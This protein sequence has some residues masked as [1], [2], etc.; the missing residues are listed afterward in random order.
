MTAAAAAPWMRDSRVARLLVGIIAISIV[1]LVV[2]A[3]VTSIV[4]GGHAQLHAMMALVPALI[5]YGIVVRFPNAG[6][7]SRLPAFGLATLAAAWVVESFGGYGYGPDND[8]RVNSFVLLHDLGLTLVPLG[9][10]AA[11]LGVAAGVVVAARGR[12]GA[13]RWLAFAVVGLGLVGGSLS[14][15][16]LTG[17]SPFG[18]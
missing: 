13:V 2:G 12:A 15:L 18:G 11:L 3:L 5:G 6:A 4:A 17:L 8:S 7:A 10:V 14:L 16:T 9:M 1:Q